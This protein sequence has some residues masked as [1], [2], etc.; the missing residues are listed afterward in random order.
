[1]QGVIHL[2]CTHFLGICYPPPSTWY[3]IWRHCYYKLAYTMSCDTPGC[4]RKTAALLITRPSEQPAPCTQPVKRFY[5]LNARRGLAEGY[6][7]PVVIK[8]VAACQIYPYY[9]LVLDPYVSDLPQKYPGSANVGEVSCCLP[10]ICPDWMYGPK[11]LPSL[12]LNPRHMTTAVDH[13]KMLKI[14]KCC[15]L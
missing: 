14:A 4:A 10:W 11:P 13:G 2:V 7:G 3:A 8:A 9:L 15:Y 1:M 5:R 6:V 12:K